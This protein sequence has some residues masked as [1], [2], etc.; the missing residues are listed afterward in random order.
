MNLLRYIVCQFDV[1]IQ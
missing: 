1:T